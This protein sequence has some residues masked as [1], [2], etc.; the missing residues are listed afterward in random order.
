MQRPVHTVIIG[1]LRP[2]LVRGQDEDLVGF[3]VGAGSLVLRNGVLGF[4]LAFRR[5]IPADFVGGR[6]ALIA[7]ERMEHL[8]QRGQV[9][10]RAAH[11]ERDAD[12]REVIT[13]GVQ[14]FHAGHTHEVRRAAAADI[15]IHTADTGHIQLHRAGLGVL[16][17]C[18]VID[19]G[20]VRTG[21]SRGS[22]AVA[23]GGQIGQIQTFR[24]VSGLNLQRTVVLVAVVCIGNCCDLRDICRPRVDGDYR[25]TAVKGHIAIPVALPLTLCKQR[26]CSGLYRSFIAAV[27]LDGAVRQPHVGDVFIILDSYYHARTRDQR[28]AAGLRFRHPR[29]AA[30]TH[31]ADAGDLPRQIVR[32]IVTVFSQRHVKHK[33]V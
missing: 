27:K 5:V 2:D 10:C 30:R 9:V 13:G 16:N 31:A 4:P 17:G 20:V 29:A 11:A 33:F 6:A 23:R 3:A 7:A 21:I 18:C 19:I 1:V 22:P 12:E 26:G 28:A 32:D 14:V 15:L 25:T 24:A 8:D